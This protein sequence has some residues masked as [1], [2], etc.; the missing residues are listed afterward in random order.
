MEPS[1]PVARFR[2]AIGRWGLSVLLLGFAVREAFSFWTGNPYDLESWVRTGS[3]VARGASPYPALAPPVPGVSFV[4]PGRSFSTAAYPPFWPL[5]LGL[6][7]RTW[8][9]YG[10]GN[11][12][13]LYFLLKQ[14]VILADVGLAYLLG[15]LVYARSGN[16]AGARGV[17]AFW[18][19]F[20]YAIAISGVCGQFDPIEAL[21]LVGSLAVAAEIRRPALEGLGI[22]VKWLTIIF[23][24]L[25]VMRVTGWSRVRS[26]VL[27]VAP[28]VT[29]TLA[30][31]AIARWPLPGIEGIAATQA[32]GNRSGMNLGQLFQNASLAADA[33]RI[34][35]FFW[36]FS[37]A[38]IP[39]VIVGGALA[40]RWVRAGGFASE[41]RALL[42]VVTLFLLTR[43]GLN[44]QFMIYLFAPMLVDVALYRPG[45][46]PLFYLLI[47]L[48]SAYLLVNNDLGIWYA[49]PLF[50]G[51]FSMVLHV[52]AGTPLGGWRADA[53]DVLAVAITAALAYLAYV[54]YRDLPEPFPANLSPRLRGA[55][56]RR[57]VLVGYPKPTLA[58]D[59]STP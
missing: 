9:A 59:R 17:L 10:G 15:A 41:L 8:E 37:L 7:Y 57:R 31:L 32:F 16:I 35:Y 1:P 20:P 13:A 30:I 34:P 6:L 3:L 4:F 55:A 2:T 50:P 19:L 29:A 42:F 51:T 22:F 23:L 43:F 54:L 45:R 40:A 46:R 26:A 36:A 38:W 48:C 14:P 27:V 47:G 5:T 24:P 58:R 25:E 49:A 52:N 33:N 18:S 56:R 12:F 28:P 44:E 21:V 53:L 39:A 11:R